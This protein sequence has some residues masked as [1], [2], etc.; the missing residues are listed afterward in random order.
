MLLLADCG[1]LCEILRLLRILHHGGG[2]RR[3]VFLR[4]QH[5]RRL[6]RPAM[7]VDSPAGEVPIGRADG[8]RLVALA[9]VA[10][11]VSVTRPGQRARRP[12]RRKG[13]P[14]THNARIIN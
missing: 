4:T 9:A 13:N 8:G 14:L 10:V 1:D 3:R 7:G 12:T 6:F 2:R 5:G 11:C